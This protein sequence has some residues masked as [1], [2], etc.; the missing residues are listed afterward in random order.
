MRSSAGKL[1][2]ASSCLIFV[3]FQNCSGFN[4]A[5]LEQS[6][7]S[8][9]TFSKDS[10]GDAVI[11]APV[12]GSNLII[13]TTKRLAGAIGSLT[14]NGKEF[15]NADDHGREL[16][17]AS[18]FDGFGECYNPTEAGSAPDGG[19]NTSTSQVLGLK[20]SGNQLA[21]TSQMAFWLKANQSYPNG[22][23]GN[24]AIKV[25]QNKT[26]ISN[27]TL[28]KQ[29]TIGYK[30]IS[31][32]IEYLVTFHVP[33][34]HNAAVFEALT[35]YMGRDF[36]SFWT[37]NPESGV[38]NTLSNGPGEQNIPVILSTPDR[39]YAM[40]IFAPAHP[41]FPN[42]GYGRFNF[43]DQNTMK[44]NAV[45]RRGDT[46]AGDYSFRLYVIVGNLDQVQQGMLQ[47]Y[48]SFKDQVQQGVV[49]INQSFKPQVIGHIDGISRVG[50]DFYLS[51]WACAQGINKSLP[52]HLYLN[53]PAGVGH[54]Y[55]AYSAN[56][57]N[58]AGVAQSCNVGD[59][60]Y[61]FSIPLDQNM[62]RA[63]GGQSIYVH[64]I[65]PVGLANLALD[66]SGSFKV[67][68]LDET[69]P[70]PAEQTTFRFL[71]SSSGEHFITLSYNEGISAGYSYE[72]LAFMSYVSSVNLSNPVA[73]YRCFWISAR[74][75]FVSIDV[76]CEG[77]QQEG[78]LGYAQTIPSPNNL[79][80]YRFL[81]PTTHDHLT[82][83]NYTEGSAN[84]YQ[85]EGILA[86]VPAK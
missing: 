2:L 67:P 8:S 71:R 10:E 74:M 73:L 19:G 69:A 60:S 75:H 59:G 61:R 41:D 23:G 28:S 49:Q 29:V 55:S 77:S 27:H 6:S 36:S 33:E 70:L 84:G 20:A 80:L 3:F 32:A 81:H 46:P 79:P 21:T 1:L 37:F 45:F 52:V 14:W 31:N 47:V 24:A 44:W 17:S 50:G 9:K 18:S 56:L 82:T 16:Q 43:Y 54:F 11:S 86:Y 72:G 85:F 4:A 48:Q 63:Y 22:C 58:E 57:P 35:G 78:L 5:Q 65:S 38:L 30:G 7:L 64:G 15:I 39:N 66:Q 42:I 68:L 12:L 13:T 83:T 62:R 25:A 76:N 53:G 26:D 40:G 34:H 51:G